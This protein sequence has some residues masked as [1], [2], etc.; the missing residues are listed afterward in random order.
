MDIIKEIGKDNK[1]IE[2]KKDFIFTNA[3]KYHIKQAEYSKIIGK[4]II[5]VPKNLFPL[6][7]Y[8]LDVELNGG[9]GN[10]NINF[11]S[12]TMLGLEIRYFIDD[13]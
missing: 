10:G 12:R 9:V 7:C 1:W 13:G 4:E 6:F 5:I 11:L 8:I 2:F 3:I